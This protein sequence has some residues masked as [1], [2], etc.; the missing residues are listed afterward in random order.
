VASQ[1]GGMRASRASSNGEVPALRLTSV[2]MRFGGVVAVS[3]VSMTVHPGQRWAVIGPNGAG[4]TTLFKTVAGEL[5]PTE[6]TIELFGEDVTRKSAD[7]RA[8]RGIGRTYQIT[9]LFKGLSVEEN[10]ILAAQG[11]SRSRFR[12]WWP[13]ELRGEL[14]ERV[15][16]ALEQLQLTHVR[17]RLVLE[18]SH[19]EQ[20]QLELALALAG[21]PSVLLLDEPAAGLS[22][23]ERILMK[24]LINALPT[25][26]TVVLIE[27][28][29]SLALELVERVLAMDNGVT[30][31]EG[32][33]DEIRLNERVQ[34]VYLKS[35]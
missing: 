6:G 29:M 11:L 13:V 3:D 24:H 30:I 32:T 7:R 23:S 2:T 28:D 4:K 25:D 17:R 20:R 22:A 35:D 19:G 18:L 1:Q 10:V 15:D 31:A 27:H 5:V 14:A 8:H 34:A 9:N 16:W 21:R 12:S 33:P 26:L